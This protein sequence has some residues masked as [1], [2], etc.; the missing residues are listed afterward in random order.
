MLQS[1]IDDIV[2][3]KHKPIISQFQ[4]GVIEGLLPDVYPII[5]REQGLVE[6]LY[7][8]R[9]QCR[10]LGS[11]INAMGN[12]LMNSTLKGLFFPRI[13]ASFNTR[14]RGVCGGIRQQTRPVIEKL[15][16]LLEWSGG[17]AVA[18]GSANSST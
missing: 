14:L 11:S 10:M 2:S 1:A 7:R 8:L 9:M 12:S 17:T 5:C 18:H 15:E 16:R 6:D 4:L 3:E 13:E